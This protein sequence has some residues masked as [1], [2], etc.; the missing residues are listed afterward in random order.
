MNGK[1]KANSEGFYFFQAESVITSKIFF[2]LKNFPGG[3]TKKRPKISKKKYRKIALFILFQGGSQRKKRPKNSK[4]RPKNSTIKP[5]CTIFVPYLKI[6]GEPRPS[7]PP[8][9]TPVH[10]TVYSCLH[11]RRRAKMFGR[12]ARRICPNG[13]NR[14]FPNVQCVLKKKVFT[15]IFAHRIIVISKRNR[16]Y[17]KQEGKCLPGPPAPTPMLA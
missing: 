13:P 11:S 14:I 17:F 2:K 5:L 16:I 3:A 8:L 12:R 1:V 15:K 7:C 4:K 10:S 9:P 6:Q